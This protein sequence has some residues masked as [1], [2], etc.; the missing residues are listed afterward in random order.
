MRQAAQPGELT[1]IQFAQIRKRVIEHLDRNGG[2]RIG[3]LRL[4]TLVADR[5]E[6]AQLVCHAAPLPARAVACG[7]VG[8]AT[9]LSLRPERIFLNPPEG[10]CD[11]VVPA[12]VQDLIYL[13]DHL[14]LRVVAFHN[15]ELVLKLP[16]ASSQ[17][18]VAAGDS[19]H[20]GWRAQ[21]CHA[22]D[23]AA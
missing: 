16:N 3:R 6:L 12:R 9:L 14:R 2:L 7:G 22:L 20:I 11:V 13:G 17:R 18:A 15:Q 1:F 19:I 21:D 10:R 8:S 5:R 23:V 4:R